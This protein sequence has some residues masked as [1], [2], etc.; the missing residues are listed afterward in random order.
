MTHSLFIIHQ[1]GIHLPYFFKFYS[2]TRAI[3]EN[4]IDVCE[5]SLED[6]FANPMRFIYN[7]LYNNSILCIRYLISNYHA[8]CDVYTYTYRYIITNKKKSV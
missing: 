6:L 8:I 1:S 2:K 7:A 4:K 3:S 5:M